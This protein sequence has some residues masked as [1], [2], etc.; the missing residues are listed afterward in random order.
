MDVPDLARKLATEVAL[1]QPEAFSATLAAAL[2]DAW[3]EGRESGQRGPNGLG[4]PP[5]KPNPYRKD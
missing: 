4:L 3:D 5:L 1:H 2:A